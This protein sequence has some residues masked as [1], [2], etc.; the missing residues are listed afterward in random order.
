[1]EVSSAA[2]SI[3][4]SSNPSI[5]RKSSGTGHTPKLNKSNTSI[6][7][8]HLLEPAEMRHQL[9]SNKPVKILST[10]S[11]PSV[12]G[13]GSLKSSGSGSLFQR[14]SKTFSLRFGNTS[15]VGSKEDKNHFSRKKNKSRS[16]AI[17][18]SPDI[19]SRID[20]DSTRYGNHFYFYLKLVAVCNLQF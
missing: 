8:L 13:N 15:S 20:T 12:V 19:L 11:T 10:P 16:S 6:T 14:F 17:G 9:E 3:E 2:Q 1:M 18:S 7:H 5:N 4:K